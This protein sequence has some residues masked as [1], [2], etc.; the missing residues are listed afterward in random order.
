[1]VTIVL[2]AALA[3][4]VVVASVVALV[5]ANAPSEVTVREP[6][7]QAD[8]VRFCNLASR[9]GARAALDLADAGQSA[10]PGA[11]SPPSGSAALAVSFWRTVVAR[12]PDDVHDDALAV[13]RGVEAASSGED[14]SAEVRAAADRVD[15]YIATTCPGLVED[16]GVPAPPGVVTTDPD[17]EP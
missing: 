13:L 16:P 17:G 4:G 5:L 1:V 9:T 15:R 3:V 6:E 12:A 7:R 10:G 14:P 2:W 8:A 11:T